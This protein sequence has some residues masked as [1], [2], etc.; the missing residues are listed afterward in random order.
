MA[1][2]DTPSPGAPPA[3]RRLADQLRDLTIAAVTALVVAWSM[4]L[5]GYQTWRMRPQLGAESVIDGLAMIVLLAL[6]P[7]SRSTSW[8]NGGP[9][10]GGPTGS[11]SC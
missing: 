8:P 9:A 6:L 4:V 3:A 5:A 11:V 10:G 2:Q 1:T 7:P